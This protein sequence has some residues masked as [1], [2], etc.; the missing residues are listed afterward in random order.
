[1]SK[2][3]PPPPSGATPAAEFPET[4][5]VNPDLLKI[6]VCPMAHAELR[7]EDGHLVCT[8]CGPRF[9]I[10][11]GIPVMLIEEAQLPDGVKRVEDLP[12]Y[13]EVA[14]REAGTGPK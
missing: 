6:L 14:A 13:P 7:L 12:C 11:D 2:N 10:E 8:R 3:D 1:M 5:G 9:K 4:Y